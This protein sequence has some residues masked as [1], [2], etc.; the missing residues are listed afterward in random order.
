LPSNFNRGFTALGGG[1][2]TL[3]LSLGHAIG[4]TNMLIK[5]I[6]LLADTLACSAA[7]AILERLHRVRA[8]WLGGRAAM[9]AEFFLIFLMIATCSGAEAKQIDLVC[10][11]T[12]T[13]VS[14]D[15]VKDW[16]LR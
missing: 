2:C 9:R 11:G 16:I 4:G 14:A 6:M 1:L 8:F 7:E 5:R 10:K 3:S 15:P 13:N 12:G